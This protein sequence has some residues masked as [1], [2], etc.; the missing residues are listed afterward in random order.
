MDVKKNQLTKNVQNPYRAVLFGFSTVVKY[1][2]KVPGD[3]HRVRRV[4]SS[5]VTLEKIP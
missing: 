4:D 2:D 5:L 1:V 3:G